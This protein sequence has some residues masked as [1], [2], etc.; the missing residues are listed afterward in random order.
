M[1]HVSRALHAK[2]EHHGFASLKMTKSPAFA[3]MLKTIS[4]LVSHI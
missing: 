3:E 2:A 4:W 1:P